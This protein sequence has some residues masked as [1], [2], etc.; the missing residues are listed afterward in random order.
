MPKEITEI[1]HKILSYL[2]YLD[3]PTSSK[4][5]TIADDYLITKKITVK[6]LIDY[7]RTEE[8]SAKLQ[9]QFSSPSDYQSWKKFLDS[10]ATSEDM[11][12]YG[13]WKITNVEWDN[14][15]DGS[16][17][18]AY[19]F[20]PE[21][22]Q[23]VVSFRGSEA[24]N[25]P[26]YRND[27]HNNSTT[28]YSEQARQQRKAEEYMKKYM[29]QDKYKMITLT[30][31][32]LGG[33]LALYATITAD[34]NLKD[35]ISYTSTYNAPGFNQ[36]FIDEHKAEIAVMSQ[37]IQEFQNKYDFVSLILFNVTNP[38]IIDTTGE[39]NTLN[40]ANHGL[41]VLEIGSDGMLKRSEPQV[42][43]VIPQVISDFTQ[44]LQQ[45]PRPILEGLVGA[46]FAVWNGRVDMVD[47][48]V[49]GI[50]ISAVA[51]YGILPVAGAVGLI[52]LI[53]FAPEIMKYVVVPTAVRV[54]EFTRELAHKIY[55]AVVNFFEAAFDLLVKTGQFIVKAINDFKQKVFEAVH[56]FFSFLV[57]AVQQAWNALFSSDHGAIQVDVANLRN[58]AAR[59]GNVYNRINQVD[60]QLDNLFHQVD[61]FQKLL[62]LWTDI[63][64]G[65]DGD[66]KKCIDYLNRTAD[67]IEA[68]ERKIMQ[69]AQKF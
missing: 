32:S 5:S 2:V 24:M 44:R 22:G 69:L 58:L 15:K 59:L 7:Y 55:T 43:D 1:D 62:V 8:G 50:A 57:H 41:D 28:V 47:Y 39:K 42:K 36:H 12:K 64:V 49:G 35:K 25:D 48:L 6:Q 14:E 63:R 18:V 27:W 56:G 54:I 61:I 20:E 67:S 29:S 31:H 21:E 45:L 13:D 3:I 9:E 68:C 30:G 38:I 34:S 10:F 4:S 11:Q 40:M 26:K 65:N 33:N 19:T 37:K 53:V 66:V 60:S 17:F 23:A 16:G 52:G 46:V 51:T